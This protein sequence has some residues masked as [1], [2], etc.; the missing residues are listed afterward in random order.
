MSKR[1][2]QR[3]NNLHLLDDEQRAALAKYQKDFVKAL[4]Q[5]ESLARTAQRVHEEMIKAPYWRIAETP[6]PEDVEEPKMWSVGHAQINY[7]DHIEHEG[8]QNK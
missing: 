4:P 6:K 1:K 7:V 2:T 8:T 5:M 3:R